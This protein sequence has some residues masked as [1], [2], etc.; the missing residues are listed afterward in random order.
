[1]MSALRSSQRLCYPWTPLSEECIP[2]ERC[3]NSDLFYF[4]KS[5]NV[6]SPSTVRANPVNRP[7]KSKN[8]N[9]STNVVLSRVINGSRIARVSSAAP[10]F[11]VRPLVWR[12]RPRPLLWGGSKVGSEMAGVTTW[13]VPHRPPDNRQLCLRWL[14]RMESEVRRP[15]TL[16]SNWVWRGHL[17]FFSSCGTLSP[18]VIPGTCSSPSAGG[19]KVLLFS[20]ILA[21][22]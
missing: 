13:R 4:F 8:S 12:L 17:H 11:A 5:A 1:M 19:R 7:N 3:T 20:F 16:A 10:S 14:A 6:G 18:S 2:D 21:A 15:H 22:L 9:F